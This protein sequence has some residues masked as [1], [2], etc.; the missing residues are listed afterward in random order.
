MDEYWSVM[1]RWASAKLPILPGF[2]GIDQRGDVLIDNPF[3][4]RPA[5]KFRA[6]VR[7]QIKRRPPVH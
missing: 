7:T 5:D 2:A 3:Q 1:N 6:V 4:E